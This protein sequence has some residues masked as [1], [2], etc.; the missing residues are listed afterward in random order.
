MIEMREL[1][2]DM[3]W[4]RIYLHFALTLLFWFLMVMAILLDLWDGL[5]TA[6]QLKEPIRSG[7]LRR[8]IQKAGD[9]WRIMLFG[10]LF[11]IV[12]MLFSWY[13]MPFMTLLVL[14][15]VLIIEFKSLLEHARKRKS[16]A[17]ELPAV[18]QQ[19]ISCSNSEEAIN[20]L[21]KIK[22]NSYDER[23]KQIN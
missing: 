15:A 4:P 3:N 6:K 9:Y 10:F 2:C 12:G 20:L 21:M 5:S 18:I 22:D 11:D 23:K 14:V 19:I 17:A 8:T 7:I 13:I 1:I 16:H